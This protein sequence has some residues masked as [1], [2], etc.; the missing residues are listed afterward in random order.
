MKTYDRK[1]PLIFIHVPKTAA[2]ALDVHAMTGN[3]LKISIVLRR[4][5]SQSS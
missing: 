3:G 5:L 2:A 4:L 1:K